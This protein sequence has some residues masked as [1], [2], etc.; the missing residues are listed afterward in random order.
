[1]ADFGVVLVQTIDPER[2]TYP[3]WIDPEHGADPG[4]LNP[5]GHVQHRYAR[6]GV[7]AGTVTSIF[8][9]AVVAG[10]DAPA[11]A[12]LGG[13]LFSWSMGVWPL[14]SPVPIITSPYDS[15]TSQ[16]QVPIFGRYPGHWVIVARRPGGGHVAFPFDVEIDP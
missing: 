16:A 1:M 3:V 6:V 7:S 8:F 4:R 14:D 11:D 2:V 15:K 5:R 9:H 10:V 12:A 13:R